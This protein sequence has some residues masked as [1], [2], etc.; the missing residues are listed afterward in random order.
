M[1]WTETLINGLCG[2]HTCQGPSVYRILWKTDCQPAWSVVA[3]CT[4][5]LM[6][7]FRCWPLSSLSMSCIH[8]LVPRWTKTQLCQFSLDL[9]IKGLQADL[10]VPHR[11]LMI[12]LHLSEFG[13]CQLGLNGSF[14]LKCPS[15]P[16]SKKCVQIGSMLLQ[17]WSC[18]AMTA[19][20]QLCSDL[21]PLSSS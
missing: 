6:A 16:Y 21:I 1:C 20:V 2:G 15:L 18:L 3:R 12:M 11:M 17:C 7:A 10:C 19:M 5:P 8:C 4:E 9:L 14:F 13:W